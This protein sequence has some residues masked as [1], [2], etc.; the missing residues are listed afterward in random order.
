MSI[1]I[2]PSLPDGFVVKSHSP[3]NDDLECKDFVRGVLGLPGWRPCER[4]VIPRPRVRPTK[5]E[6]ADDQNLARAAAIWDAALSP[7]DTIV[8][9]YLAGRCIHLTDTV[10]RADAI[11]F[12]PACH[13]GSGL[14]LPAMVCRFTD[15]KSGEPRGIHRT[16]LLP[17][18]SGKAKDTTGKSKAMLGP[19]AGCVIRLTANEDVTTAVGIAEGVETAL[20]VMNTEGGAVWACGSAGTVE[21]FPV[22]PGIDALT[23]WA[24]RGEAGER[25][26]NTVAARWFEAGRE[27]LF[28]LPIGDDDFNSAIMGVSDMASI[29]IDDITADTIRYGEEAAT[30]NLPVIPVDPGNIVNVIFEV[31]A[32]LTAGG[33]LYQRSGRLVRVARFDAPPDPGEIDRRGALAILDVT[34]EWLKIEMARVA[35]FEK[36]DAHKKGYKLIDPPIWLAKDYNA[37]CG[38]WSVKSLRGI[39]EAPTIREDGSILPAPG[40]DRAS[41][42]FFDPGSMKFPKI[43]E[44]PTRDDGMRALERI[45]SLIGEFPFASDAARSVALAAILTALVRKSVRTAPMFIFEAAKMGSGKSLLADIV[46]MI[47]TGRRASVMSQA[48]D[49]AEEKKRILAVLMAGD[50]VTVIDNVEYPLGSAALCAVLTSDDYRDRI[51]GQTAQVSVPTDT[52]F[53][54]T[55]NNVTVI[56]DLSTRVLKARLDVK[57]EHP[58]ERSFDWSPID[59]IE[60]ERPDIVAAALT[61]IRSYIVAGRPSVPGKTFGRFEEWSMMVRNPLVWL[62]RADP[63]DTRREI[64]AIDPVREGL[65]AIMDAWGA[66]F[67]VGWATSGEVVAISS[68]P[69]GVAMTE[70][71]PKRNLSAKGVTAYLM[72]VRGR[73]EGGRRFECTE[74][75][76]AIKWRLV[77]TG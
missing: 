58:E 4:D 20:T 50:P 53:L 26:A 71:M 42:L 64:E 15:A 2:D 60:R 51:L 12:H 43:P 28:K 29:S 41:C 74:G 66:A 22:L 17:D 54:V 21:R 49:E 16:Y 1:K 37:M 62:G 31:N 23:V 6:P 65:L 11:R 48:P 73:T 46:S 56:G 63:C 76:K 68:S 10:I 24:D 40:Y 13:A 59:V 5:P 70:E 3:A 33:N 19:S 52:T 47:A 18:G 75:S 45:E 35:R 72:H 61:V 34:D 39:I 36:Y 25:A 67:G 77:P 30:S 27:A 44:N 14:R 8:E 32:A 7:V 55:G 38:E 57:D 69:I 9:T